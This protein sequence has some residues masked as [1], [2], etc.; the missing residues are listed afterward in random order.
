MLSTSTANICTF[1]DTREKLS[2]LH[3]K[4]HDNASF[5]LKVDTF[6]WCNI[7]ELIRLVHKDKLEIQLTI[8][9]TRFPKIINTTYI[10]Y[11][12]SEIKRAMMSPYDII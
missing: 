7:Y 11:E 3:E 1:V 6:E 12:S 9:N 2:R 10:I 8:H 5:V 4:Y